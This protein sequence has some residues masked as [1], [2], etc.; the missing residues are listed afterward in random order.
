MK[1]CILVFPGQGSQYVGMTGEMRKDPEIKKLLEEADDILQMPLS[2]HM[3][4][5]P[6]DVLTLTRNAQPA[7]VLHSYL[8]WTKVKSILEGEGIKIEAVLGHSVGEFSALLVA[9]ALTFEQA[10][11]ITQLR[12]EAMQQATPLGVGSMYAI[13]RVPADLIQVACLEVSQEQLIVVPANYNSPDQVVISGHKEACL[14][15]IDWLEKNFNG[16]LRTVELSVSA[17]FH[18]PLMKPAENKFADYISGMS[19]N[20][21]QYPYYAN[22]NAQYYDAGT[23]PSVIKENLI[24]QISGSVLWEQS[25]QKFPPSPQ[26][27]EIG[28]GKILQGLIKKTLPQASLF[29]M[30]QGLGLEDELKLLKEWAT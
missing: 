2:Q 13:L 19:L 18:S 6:G 20:T 27:L 23:A 11:K 1:K 25:V 4:S 28:P 21:N 24:L 7:I 9:G 29:S 10:L 15:A 14:A 5:G 12:G 26:I 3:L 8:Y 30:D 16:R 22:I 17:P